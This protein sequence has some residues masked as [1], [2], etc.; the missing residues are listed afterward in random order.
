LCIREIGGHRGDS[1]KYHNDNNKP[2][3]MQ[4]SL[5]FGPLLQN[6][7]H[8]GY[9]G[10]AFWFLESMD[11]FNIEKK[12]HVYIYDFSFCIDAA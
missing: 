1:Q 3:I 11:I 8:K 2:K 6:R 9:T 5:A 7:F 12:I 10:N 4:N